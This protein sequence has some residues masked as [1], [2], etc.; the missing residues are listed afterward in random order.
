MK[1][2][3]A[4]PEGLR[5]RL[6][7]AGAAIFAL[8][9]ALALVRA[10][11][12][13]A[14]LDFIAG[15]SLALLACGGA[16]IL[17]GLWIWQ[18]IAEATALATRFAAGETDLRL[19]ASRGFTSFRRLATVLNGLA[20]HINDREAQFRLVSEATG[21]AVWR[22]TPAT[23]DLVWNGKWQVIFGGVGEAWATSLAAWKER[24]HPD[25][26]ERVEASFHAAM[27][28]SG[29]TWSEEYRLL[30]ADGSCR[31]FWDRA[32]ILRD[33]SGRAISVVGCMT[34]IS[35]QRADE[36]RIWNLAHRDELTGLPNRTLFQ[37]RIDAMMEGGRK[38]ALLLLDIDHFKEVNDT[39]GHASGDALLVCLANRLRACV[40]GSGI[41]C[42]LGGD[43]FAVLLPSAN[44]EEAAAAAQRIL[45]VVREPVESEA[46]VIRPRAT[47]GVALVPEH[48]ATPSEIMKSADIA[49]YNGK[50]EGRDRCAFFE[51]G[52]RAAIQ[53]RSD[54]IRDVRDGLERNEFQPYYQPIVSI[55]DGS[56]RAVEALMRW[57]HHALGILPP[58]RF[59]PTLADA[60]VAIAFGRALVIQVLAD[61][62][63]WMDAGLAPDYIA[64]NVSAA[65]LRLPDF[66]ERI[67]MRLEQAGVPFSSLALEITETVLFGTGSTNVERSLAALHSAGVRIALD[68]FG[69]GYASLTHL[70]QVPVDIIKIDQSFVRSIVTDRGSQ[71]IVSAILELGRGLGKNVIAEGVETEEHA[72]MLR[73]AGC[74]EAQGYLYAR[75][76]PEK[77]LRRYLADQSSRRGGVQ[78]LLPSG[79]LS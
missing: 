23:D 56:V 1:V 44:A 53:A 33:D 48:G 79:A 67:L 4:D 75:P 78:E 32:V 38:G 15:A 66:A 27:D 76:M 20:D 24:I 63:G 36:E 74:V 60:E 57:N 31:W 45:V 26:R 13:G 77:D 37:S 55:A 43:E 25:D 10:L 17:L 69:T 51:P 47:I 72:L 50:A 7:F 35:R 6:A 29:R 70:R 58:A 41:I 42:R 16:A 30:I 14:D 64:V 12:S 8:V 28:G 59:L 46:D 73:A 2:K 34:D 68:D 61:Y 52:L 19:D 22:W 65:G 18:P 3:T 11:A 9:T 71:A 49:L 54:L 5:L 21:D 62:R 39:L 40:P